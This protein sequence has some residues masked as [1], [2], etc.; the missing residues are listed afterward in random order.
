MAHQLRDMM[1]WL[2]G[3]RWRL[4]GSGR[5]AGSW[6]VISNDSHRRR[7]APTIAASSSLAVPVSVPPTWPLIGSLAASA[8][9]LAT[10]LSDAAL[11]IARSY[12]SCVCLA[13]VEIACEPL[14]K[15]NQLS[16]THSAERS[17]CA[18]EAPV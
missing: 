7:C 16:P 14:K 18:S 4:T 12:L 11:D 13:W 2:R 3:G 8:A 17:Q 6:C 1:G 10:M 5:A 9:I 15:K